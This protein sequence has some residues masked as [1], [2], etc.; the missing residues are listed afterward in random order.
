MTDPALTEVVEELVPQMARFRQDLHRNPEPAFK[1]QA[2]SEA[3]KTLLREADVPM[4]PLEGTGVLGILEGRGQGPGGC[5]ALRA[6]MDALPVEEKT[7]LSYASTVPGMMHACGH[8]GNTAALAGAARIL[9][10]LR[11]RF[12]GTVKFIF[13]PGEESLEG[14]KILIDQGVLE[15]PKV[16]RIF[17][18]HGWPDLPVGKIGIYQGNYMAMAGKF[19]LTLTAPGAHGGYPHQGRDTVLAAADLIQ[20]LNCIVSREINALDQAVF[21]VCTVNGGTAF[22]VMPGKV[23]LS[24]TYRCLDFGVAD[25]LKAAV[26]RVTRGVAQAND[27][28]ADLTFEDLVPVL[29]NSPSGV[30]SVQQAARAVLPPDTLEMLDRPCMGSEDFALYLSKVGDGAFIRVGVTPAGQDR[31]AP[32][33]SDRFDYNDGALPGAMT[34][35]AGIVITLHGPTPKKD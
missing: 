30:G 28:K 25:R 11:H 2:T 24:G 1:E 29:S 9:S 18:C 27:C 16:D 3:V 34:L 21:S 19:N 20:R 26:E 13:Q 17:A 35:L 33:H 12:S 10:C 31:P 32:L 23:S 6:D 22:N 15:S 14:A 4:V 8:D 7:G 5:T